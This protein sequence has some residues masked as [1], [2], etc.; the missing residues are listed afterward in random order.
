MDGAAEQSVSLQPAAEQQRAD[1]TVIAKG[2]AVS[3]ELRG[4]DSVLVEGTVTGGIKVDGTVTVARSGLVKGPIEAEDV[5]VAGSVTGDITAR[6]AVRL[7][8]TGSITGSVTMRSFTIE[9]GGYFN[10]QS[11]MTA[12]GAEPVIL[13]QGTSEQIAAH[14]LTADFSP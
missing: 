11:H 10:G 13:Y 12:S 6:A 9:D 8:M 14:N 5:Y 7:E 2:T 3:G 4:T 1:T